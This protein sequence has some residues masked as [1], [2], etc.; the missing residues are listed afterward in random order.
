MLK[1]YGV[2]SMKVWAD[3]KSLQGYRREHLH[4]A[5]L[6]YLPSYSAEVEGVEGVA[7]NDPQTAGNL[8]DLPDL[9]ETRTPESA[10]V[11]LV[12]KHGANHGAS[13]D[14]DQIMAELSASDRAELQ[15]STDDDRQT[16]AEMLAHR[17][18]NTGAACER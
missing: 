16:W 3:G 6:R 9:P 8:P 7:G 13:L 18:C 10:F 12:R 11:E 4:D 5:W 17:L 1:P 14:S 2:H 15:T